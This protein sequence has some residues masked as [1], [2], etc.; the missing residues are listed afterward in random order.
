MFV[1][2]LP[3][4][5]KLQFDHQV[6]VL[7]IA[8]NVSADLARDALAGCVDGQLV[9]TSFVIRCDTELAIITSRDAEGLDIIRHSTAHLL[10]HAVKQLF[11][12]V[13]ITIGPV[14]ENGFYYDFSYRGTFTPD[15][16]GAIEQKMHELVKQNLPIVREEMSREDAIKLFQKMGEKYKAE[17]IADI[18]PEQT[19]SLYRQGNFVD[20]CRGPHVPR[21]G[22][23]GVFKLMKVAGAY[24]RGSSDNEM[25]QRIY[26]TAFVRQSDLQLYLDRLTEAE[27]RDHRKI[28]KELDLFHNQPEAP[29]MIFWHNKGWRL[30]QT[31]VQYMRKAIYDH[32]YQEV[33]APL[34]MDRS[35]WEKSGHWAKYKD[36]MFMTRSEDREYAIKPMNCPGHVQIYNQGLKSYRDLPIRMAEFGICHRNEFSGTLHG[37]IRVRQFVQDDGHVFCTEEQLQAEIIDLIN[38]TYKTYRDFGFG[39]ILVHLATRPK[40]RIGADEVWD[41]SEKA[42]E[43]ALVDQGIA[44]ELAEGEGAFYG[45]KIEFHLRDCLD[46]LWQCGTIQV[47]FS[48][49]ERLGAQYVNSDGSRKVPIMIH[50]AILGSVDRFI[51]VLLEHYAGMLPVWLSPIQVV[52]MNITDQQAACVEDVVKL[53]KKHEIKAISDLRNEKIGFKIRERTLERIPYLLVIGNREVENHLVTV[54]TRS[55]DNL[56]SMSVKD[57]VQYV[58]TQ[59]DAYH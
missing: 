19:I 7:E 56:G 59:I 13:Q 14:I 16:F 31:I 43:V 1:V 52:V 34:I 4:D 44:F 58:Q 30:F 37:L 2:R 57:F 39:D 24:W 8:R 17:I 11:P 54:R 12:D 49:P 5:Q 10:A 9:D 27:K 20:L 38:L 25:L 32:D 21:T 48:M 41:R 35:L 29:G 36:L 3:H 28:G 18:P 22:H 45:P 42:L 51:G 46:H 55:G 33:F 53:L 26:G 40:M 6:T 23:L 47:D 50:R 15:D